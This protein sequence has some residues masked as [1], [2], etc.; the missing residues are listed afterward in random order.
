MYFSVKEGD[1]TYWTHSSLI[2]EEKYDKIKALH[3]KVPTVQNA[4]TFFTFYGL[5]E[6]VNRVKQLKCL[7]IY[8]RIGVVAVPT[9]LARL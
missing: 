7:N 4:F 9:L 6:A 8:Y 3:A 2:D 5:M 1:K